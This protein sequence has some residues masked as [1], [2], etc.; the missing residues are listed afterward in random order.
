MENLNVDSINKAVSL[1]ESYS[2]DQLI[3]LQSKNLSS[4]LKKN[5]IDIYYQNL[6]QY[7]EKLVR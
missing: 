7:I 6:K 1:V 4:V 3:D 2:D 5:N